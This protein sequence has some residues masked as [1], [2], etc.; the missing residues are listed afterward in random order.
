ME[1]DQGAFNRLVGKSRGMVKLSGEVR[2][3]DSVWNDRLTVG[4]LPIEQYAHELFDIKWICR[5]YKVQS[6]FALSC[7]GFAAA[8]CTLCSNCPRGEA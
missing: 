5:E 2:R 3:A 6:R 1:Q 7:A 4:K 8:M